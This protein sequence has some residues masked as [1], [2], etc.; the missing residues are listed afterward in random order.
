MKIKIFLRTAVLTISL[1]MMQ[2]EF[3]FAT[4]KTVADGKK[5]K[6]VPPLIIIPVILFSVW[7]VSHRTGVT[8]KD[9]KRSLPGDDVVANA[10]WVINRSAVLDAPIDK[11]WP[12]IQQLGKDRAGWY[13]PNWMETLYGHHALHTID[14][15]Y[16]HV[17]KGDLLDDW[18]PGYQRVLEIEPQHLLLVDEVKKVKSPTTGKDSVVSLDF[19]VLTI[20]E[21][22]DST[23]TR[24][25]FRLRTKV[26]ALNYIPARSIG[27]LFDFSTFKI[28]TAGLN[29]R[30]RRGQQ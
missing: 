24:I 7:L 1:L 13:A 11:V 19:T 22:I 29:E 3:V 21:K 28:M 25:I 2:A 12:W 4:Q 20:L 30:L 8:H 15:A 14:T 10:N 27:G 18:G 16:Q 9:I 17:K 5:T 6:I 26:S 23:H